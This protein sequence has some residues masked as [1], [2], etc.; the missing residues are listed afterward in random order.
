MRSFNVGK[1]SKQQLS[2]R[3]ISTIELFK[4]KFLKNQPHFKK[5]V[6]TKSYQKHI[7]PGL[8]GSFL[9][10]RLYVS[11]SDFNEPGWTCL[12]LIYFG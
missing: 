7:G 8:L 9:N 12:E 2:E 3:Q 6:V 1:L 5:S 4:D 11:F 10:F